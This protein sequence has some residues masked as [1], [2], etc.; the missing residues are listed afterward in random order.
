MHGE[1]P[2]LIAIKPWLSGTADNFSQPSSFRFFEVATIQYGSPPK[3]CQV[4]LLLLSC[5]LAYQ[6]SYV[7]S[8]SS[9]I[10]GSPYTSH[11]FSHGLS[12]T[13]QWLLYVPPGSAL[14]TSTFC[15]HRVFSCFVWISEKTA[16]I[17]LHNTN[18]LVVVTK[19]WCVYR[20]VRTES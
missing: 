10:M 14:K 2:K 4:F 13:P 7:F 3:L 8:L 12:S 11:T 5:M 18:L 9:A 15:P 6:T 16:I 19:L 17:S 1:K 20:A